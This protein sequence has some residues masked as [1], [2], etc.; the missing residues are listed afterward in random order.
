MFSISW[1]ECLGCYGFSQQ[2]LLTRCL[3]KCCKIPRNAK[4]ML[5]IAQFLPC[6]TLHRPDCVSSL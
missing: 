6:I 1:L 4:N 5:K 2:N 3:Q